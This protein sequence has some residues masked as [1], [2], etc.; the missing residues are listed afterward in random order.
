VWQR[1]CHCS[2]SK[3]R[4]SVSTNTD[5]FNRS[6][7]SIARI[8]NASRTAVG[9]TQPPIQWV[10]RALSLGVKW[11]GCEADHSPPSS[12]EVKECVDLYLH[13][14]N[15]PSWRGARLKHT[16]FTFTL[17]EPKFHFG[18]S[19]NWTKLKY[20]S[21]VSIALGDWLED[22]S[23]RVRFP[24]GAGN[25]SLLHRVQNGS[26]ARSASHPMGTVGSFPGGKA[27]R[28]WSWPLTSF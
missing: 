18:K 3:S 16:D 25:F 27:A 2:S 21:S 11:P 13:S 28:A 15:T 12:V 8:N 5:W 6:Q 20:W 10:L 24:A 9:A 22:R 26:G 17:Y 23:S 7:N 4:V 19:R 1:L 14:P